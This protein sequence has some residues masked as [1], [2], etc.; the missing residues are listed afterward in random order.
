MNLALHKK[1]KHKHKLR[2]KEKEKKRKKKSEKELAALEELAAAVRAIFIHEASDP[3]LLGEIRTALNSPRR[4]KRVRSKLI[5][6]M[7]SR[8]RYVKYLGKAWVNTKPIWMSDV[9]WGRLRSALKKYN[10]TMKIEEV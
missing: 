9:S 6:V 5:K 3:L 10:K 1:K 8:G 2:E 7:F 4:S